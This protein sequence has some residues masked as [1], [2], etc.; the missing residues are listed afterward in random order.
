MSNF[1]DAIELSEFNHIQPHGGI[2]VLDKNLKV[3]QYSQNIIKLLGMTMEQLLN[4]P[5]SA[6]LES[7]IIDENISSW[8][9]QNNNK[10]KRID[11]KSPQIKIKISDLPTSST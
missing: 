4:S 5:V 1:C 3:T 9:I 11:W 8:L 7:E 6:F 10:Y 2:L